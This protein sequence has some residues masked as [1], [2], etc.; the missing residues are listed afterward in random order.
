MKRIALALAL[1]ASTATAETQNFYPNSYKGVSEKSS[2]I[3]S[4]TGLQNVDVEYGA[5]GMN[6]VLSATT[7]VSVSLQRR[8]SNG[9]VVISETIG[10]TAVPTSRTFT[11]PF[12]NFDVKV[13]P[14]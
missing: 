12:F 4:A 2:Q 3:T 11:P 6:V 9:V 5:T 14:P 8:M 10:L 13:S 1:L 7:P